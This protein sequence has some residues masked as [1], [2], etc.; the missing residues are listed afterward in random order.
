[1][2]TNAA[3]FRKINKE[4]KWFSS[5]YNVCSVQCGD[6][7]IHVGDINTVGDV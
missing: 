6:I 5:R 2:I 7:M 1:M 3:I 4:A